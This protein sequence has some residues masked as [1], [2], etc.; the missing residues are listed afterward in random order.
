MI[1]TI[2]V[3]VLTAFVIS[4]IS[5]GANRP[6]FSGSS[7]TASQATT[8]TGWSSNG[9]TTSTTQQISSG[10]AF[11]STVLS[12][13]TAFIATAGSYTCFD[14]A[15]SAC[16][17]VVSGNGSGQLAYSGSLVSM[18]G[19][20]F[21][22][23]NAVGNLAFSNTAPTVT[24]ACTA[25]TILN[26]NSVSFQMD[27]GSACATGTVVLGLPAATNG[28]ECGGYNK[29]TTASAIRQTAD[30]T[31]SATLVNF[32]VVGGASANFTSGD[33]LVISCTAR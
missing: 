22:A 27:V 15:G 2:L 1:K 8:D 30:T 26:G 10:G 29:T 16:W 18:A 6:R 12:G 28:W 23:T 3:A 9:V 14:A 33:D 17:R 24:S 31:T 21:G 7:Y 25:P 4:G 19:L 11:N 32:T 5:Y 20:A 13:Q